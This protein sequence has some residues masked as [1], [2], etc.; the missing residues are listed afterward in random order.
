MKKV[1]ISG[2]KN[3]NSTA[4]VRHIVTANISIQNKVEVLQIPLRRGPPGPPGPSAVTIPW[5][6]SNW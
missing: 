4:H 6:V 3:V 1:L 5:T 2:I